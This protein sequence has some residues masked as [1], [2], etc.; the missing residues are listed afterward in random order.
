MCKYSYCLY[1]K[2]LRHALRLGINK[3]S[4]LNAYMSS[5]N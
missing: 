3:D 2:V 5:R 4:A 1:V